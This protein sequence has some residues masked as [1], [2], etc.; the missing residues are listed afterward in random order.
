[1]VRDCGSLVVL[2]KLFSIRNPKISFRLAIYQGLSKTASKGNKIC[3]YSARRRPV[4]D[5]DMKII[6]ALYRTSFFEKRYAFKVRRQ[7]EC[8]C[9]LVVSSE[10]KYSDMQWIKKI[11]LLFEL[12]KIF[13]YPVFVTIDP[14]W[15]WSYSS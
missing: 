4:M 5:V 9:I 11:I 13:L 1:M 14:V 15:P 2:W 7:M 10:K 8:D 12:P 6:T 3:F